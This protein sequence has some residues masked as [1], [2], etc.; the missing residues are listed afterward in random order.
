MVA[1]GVQ[2]VFVS[3]DQYLVRDWR[4]LKLNCQFFCLNVPHSSIG[5]WNVLFE[6]ASLFSDARPHE[7]VAVVRVFP[8]TNGAVLCS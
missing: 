5:V 3:A 2:L 4:M 7:N 6:I 8:C 1:L